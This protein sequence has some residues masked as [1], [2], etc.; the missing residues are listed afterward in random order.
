[1]KKDFMALIKND[2]KKLINK[3]LE[4]I[5]HME[6]NIEAF[7]FII[8]KQIEVF[9]MYKE[10]E[11]H[12]QKLMDKDTSISKYFRVEKYHNSKIQKRMLKANHKIYN[13]YGFYHTFFDLSVYNPIISIRTKN[14]FGFQF[15]HSTLYGNNHVLISG[16]NWNLRIDN[17]EDLLGKMDLEW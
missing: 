5:E 13:K 9:R 12:I 6:Q 2:I 11:E 3:E 16:N 10:K 8:E 14:G 1:M 7:K 4:Q 15:C 17:E